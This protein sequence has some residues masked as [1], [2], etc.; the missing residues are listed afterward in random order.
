MSIYIAD[1]SVNRMIV[2]SL[3]MLFMTNSQITERI[4]SLCGVK[5]I[6]VSE[7]LMQCKLTKSFIYDLEKRNTSPS[8]DKIIKIADFLQVSVDYLLGRAESPNSVVNGNISNSSVAQTNGNN[9][10]QYIGGGASANTTHD[11]KKTA[12]SISEKFME[13][14]NNLPFE[15]QLSVMNFAVEKSKK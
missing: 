13:I 6:S 8:C 11:T 4:K 7:L 15:D 12:D 1:F 2:Q 5:N 14:F 10:Q 9:N 3:E